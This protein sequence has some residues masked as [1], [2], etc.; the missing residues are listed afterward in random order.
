MEKIR[1]FAG[2]LTGLFFGVS[3]FLLIT[4]SNNE[5]AE[6]AQ[7]PDS[8]QRLKLKVDSH[9]YYYKMTVDNVQYIIV[10]NHV[11]GGV[12]IIKHK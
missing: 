10:E 7:T 1:F 6:E 2:L 11:D 8:I 12:A 4:C 5:P 3:L 9:S